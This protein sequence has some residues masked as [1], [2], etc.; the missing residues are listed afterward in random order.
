MNEPLS[1]GD[2][3][4]HEILAKIATEWQKTPL[5]QKAQAK[6]L[7]DLGIV[8]TSKATLQSL[9]TADLRDRYWHLWLCNNP[10]FGVPVSWRAPLDKSPLARKIR[11]VR[12]S[13]MIRI[14]KIV[15]DERKEVLGAG[16]KYNELFVEKEKGVDSIVSSSE[17]STVQPI[18]SNKAHALVTA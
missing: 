18:P 3:N 5:E 14:A 12:K 17:H 4:V 6:E 9:S 1:T 15:T 7:V 8:G 11:H 13:E 10:H 2:T 16:N